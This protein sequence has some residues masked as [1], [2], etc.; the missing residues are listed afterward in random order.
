VNAGHTV[1]KRFVDTSG[2]QFAEAI[3][4]LEQLRI[5]QG[6]NPPY[7]TEFCPAQNVSRGQMAVFLARAFD[8]PATSADFFADDDSLFYEAAANRMAAAGL[9]K[10][11]DEGLYCGEQ[12]I[13][14][15]EMAAMLTRALSLPRSAPD[16][17]VDD[18]SSI[19][20]GAINALADAGVARGCNPPSNDR[21]CPTDRVT[22]GQ[23]A[24]FIKRAVDLPS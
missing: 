13:T 7:N 12:D 8:L 9:A 23:M 3:D 1:N 21:F 4:W 14:R 5:T 15:E 20:E 16:H 24:A 17:F 10:G 11:C 19:F 2:S 18:G 22:R 6:C